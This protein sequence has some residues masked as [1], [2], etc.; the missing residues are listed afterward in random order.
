MR[1]AGFSEPGFVRNRN[2]DAALLGD[3]II[4]DD[5]PRQIL[6]LEGEFPW[7]AVADGLGGH[8]AG[9]LASATLLQSLTSSGQPFHEKSNLNELS[10]FLSEALRVKAREKW[11]ADGMASTLTAFYCTESQVFLIHCG[12]CRAYRISDAG[13]SLIS[14]DHTLVFQNFLRGELDLEQVRAHPMK[15]RLLQCIQAKEEI[16]DLE[17][18]TVERKPGMRLLLA[19][20]GIWESMPNHQLLDL[21]QNGELKQ[22]CENVRQ[23]YYDSGARDNG[24]MI[25][26]EF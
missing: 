12:D 6:E 8:P 3:R 5:A 25:L 23:L 1:L 18:H 16:A 9:N 20:D 19:T 7:V 11:G 14:T 17:L 2:E 21:V 24:S 22:C 15:N 26:L 4:Q 10:I 13:K